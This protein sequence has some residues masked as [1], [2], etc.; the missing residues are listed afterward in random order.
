MF[1][2]DVG[3]LEEDI[4]QLIDSL[5]DTPPLWV[6]QLKKT[7]PSISEANKECCTRAKKVFLDTVEEHRYSIQRGLG[8][9]FLEGLFPKWLG[10]KKEKKYEDAILQLKELINSF[11]ISPN[12]CQEFGEFLF[13][14]TDGN[15]ENPSNV[16]L[17]E[18]ANCENE[19]EE[20]WK[21][22]LSRH[23]SDTFINTGEI[24]HG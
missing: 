8:R 1:K 14:T 6:E 11:S 23:R 5:F 2:E 7:M 16:A 17:E 4:E 9:T 3:D 22:K 13:N 18:W 12:G 15:K 21:D 20:T 19:Y 24:L 10:A